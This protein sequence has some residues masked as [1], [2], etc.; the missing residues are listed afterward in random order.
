MFGYVQK[1]RKERKDV[2][3]INVLQPECDINQ[4]MWYDYNIRYLCTTLINT[5]FNSKVSEKHLDLEGRAMMKQ[6][7]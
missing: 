7:F 4:S 2:T 6:T 3:V 5:M 1:A